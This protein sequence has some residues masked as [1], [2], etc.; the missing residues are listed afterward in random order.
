MWLGIK[1]FSRIILNL[2]FSFLFICVWISDSLPNIEKALSMKRR[3]Y[4]KILDKNSNVIGRY[5]DTQDKII[6]AQKLPKHVIF[7]IIDV[8]DKNFFNHYGVDVLGIFRSLFFNILAGKIVAGGSSITQQLAR[9]ILQ[10]EEYVSV[11]DK[12]IVRKIKETVLAFK[13]ERQYSKWEI[14]T[15]YLNRVY[16]GSGTYGIEAAAKAYFN[17]SVVDLNLY[18]AA[19]IVGLLQAP[20]RYS[21]NVNY[22]KRRQINVLSAMLRNRHISKKQFDFGKTYNIDVR[23]NFINNAYFADWVFKTLPRNLANTDL[24][25]KTTLDQEIQEKASNSLQK[26]FLEAGKEWNA[27][28]G[29]MVVI[30]KSGAVRALVGGLNYHFSKFNRVTSSRRSIGSFFKYYV[31]FEAIKRGLDPE[32]MID[33]SQVSYGAWNPSNYMHNSTTGT[34]PVRIAFA[35]SINASAVNLLQVCG[36]K[37]VISCAHLL[38]V[39][40]KIKENP[41]ITLG[42]VDISLLDLTSS[43]LVILNK[44]Y[45][46]KPYFI[47]EIR[48]AYTKQLIYKHDFVFKKVA[49]ERT[50]W[51]M[52]QLL[53]AV[54]SPYGTARSLQLEGKTVGG[55]TGTSNSYRDLLF[56]GVVPNDYVFG[57]W[58]G[59]DDFGPMNRVPGKFLPLLASKYFLLEMPNSAADLDLDRPLENNVL[60]F[61]DLL[62]Q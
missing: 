17:K 45:N 44:G 58:F 22:W 26:A 25:V 18:E 19:A 23:K 28:Q 34:V 20:S 36:I 38:G 31:Y 60:S 62:L 40:S 29:S 47:E 46:T 6:Q 10:N 4:V 35:Q 21:G 8:E 43:L 53:K 55:K 30:A 12:T 13:L 50:I 41:S 54:V 15:L 49:S 5:G 39:T 37:N 9:N 3:L 11:Y 42:G 59:R 51:Y 24:E 33:D 52:W 7:A 32:S 61:E 16:F 1:I 27:D 48:D 14:L 2:G 56:I 57:V